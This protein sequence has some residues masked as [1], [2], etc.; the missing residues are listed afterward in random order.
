MGLFWIDRVY[1]GS[2]LNGSVQLAA[3]ITEITVHGLVDDPAATLILILR[4]TTS[5]I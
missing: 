2:S 1:Y 4:P 3:G 5:P